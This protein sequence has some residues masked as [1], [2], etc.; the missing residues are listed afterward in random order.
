MKQVQH[1]HY[2][3]IP[4][5]DFAI[6]ALF[7]WWNNLY[8]KEAVRKQYYASVYFRSDLLHRLALMHNMD[9]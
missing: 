9:L 8:T 7:L 6:P 1:L 4:S 2:N 3:R 5:P